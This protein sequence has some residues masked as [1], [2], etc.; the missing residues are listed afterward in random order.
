MVAEKQ[1]TLRQLN[2]IGNDEFATRIGTVFEHSP[3]IAREAWIA[4][5]FEDLNHLHEA[6]C[7][8]VGNMS[9]EELL[10]LIQSHPDLGTKR[11]IT[12]HSASEQRRAGLA[13]L[14]AQE[15]DYLKRLSRVYRECFGFP[16]ILAVRGKSI[17]EI[18]GMMEKRLMAPREDEILLALREICR[19]A[20]FRL[21]EMVKDGT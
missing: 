14:P 15:M 20:R 18:L 16:F 6:L 2:A 4:N 21:E 5:P 9:E 13:S 3:W 19:I 8:V 7:K 17:E 10:K 12:S 1:I 11:R